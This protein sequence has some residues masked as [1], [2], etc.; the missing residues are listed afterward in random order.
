MDQVQDIART[1]GVDW[2]HLS[3]QI[4]SFSIVCGLLYWLAYKPVLAMLATRREQI[5]QGLA[6]AAKIKAELEK[7]EALRQ[8]VLARAR[9]EGDRLIAEAHEAARR[10]VAQ[11]TQRAQATAQDMLANA[12]EVT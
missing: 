5:S 6:N 9:T 3:A 1:F 2:P 4:I 10:V 8:E 12:R 7:T 11:E